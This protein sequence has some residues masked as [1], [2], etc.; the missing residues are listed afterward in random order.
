MNAAST[1]GFTDTDGAD[2][3]RVAVIAA[4]TWRRRAL[5]QTVRSSRTLQLA[6]AASRPV[7]IDPQSRI[8]VL[9]LDPGHPPQ[10]GLIDAALAT[11]QPLVVLLRQ[12]PPRVVE[13][14]NRGGA[15]VLPE[16]ADSNAVSA[17]LQCA[18]AGLIAQTP[19]QLGAWTSTAWASLPEA[20]TARECEVLSLLADGL[21][22]RGIAQALSI[23]T[24]TAKFHVAQI[25]A[26]LQATSRAQAV[27]I[28]LREGIV[29]ARESDE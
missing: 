16:N 10:E 15:S 28:A 3:L 25:L 26:K 29:A 2:R 5:E 21:P 11:E 20:L 9:L 14:L 18:A 13:T 7:E 19:A 12:A 17:A 1:D 6:G 27:A 24:H 23:S 22:N 4:E 8:D